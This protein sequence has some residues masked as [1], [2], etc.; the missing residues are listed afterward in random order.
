MTETP[1]HLQSAEPSPVVQTGATAAFVLPERVER[2]KP[3]DKTRAR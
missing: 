1:A 2:D 3:A